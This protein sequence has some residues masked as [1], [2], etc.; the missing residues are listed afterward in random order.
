VSALHYRKPTHLPPKSLRGTEKRV[1]PARLSSSE[2]RCGGMGEQSFCSSQA[3]VPR[4]CR[5]I[6]EHA[7]VGGKRVD[8]E[9][10]RGTSTAS[11]ALLPQ[12]TSESASPYQLRPTR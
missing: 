9:E 12:P 1:Q 10:P 5:G 2:R 7:S 8:L 6:Q 3:A 11:P 4:G